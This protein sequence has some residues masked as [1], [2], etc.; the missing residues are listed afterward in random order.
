VKATGTAWER[1]QD[2]KTTALF[3]QCSHGATVSQ[4]MTFVHTSESNRYGMGAETGQKDDCLISA[5]LA[6]QGLKELPSAMPKQT[7]GRSIKLY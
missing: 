6:W 3:R 5:M 4:M 7:K 1:K 2:K